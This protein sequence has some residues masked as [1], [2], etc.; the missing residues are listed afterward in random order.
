MR[1]ICKGNFGT[2]FALVDA[3]SW[4]YW[5]CSG[6]L[7]ERSP[8]LLFITNSTLEMRSNVDLYAVAYSLRLRPPDDDNSHTGEKVSI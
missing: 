8:S 7:I 1:L 5:R 2:I 3:C 4:I 6:V